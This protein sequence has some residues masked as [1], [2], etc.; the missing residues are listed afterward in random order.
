MNTYIKFITQIFLKSFIYV[1]LIMLSL[2]L[3]LNILSELDFF[4]NI[5]V[6]PLFPIYVSFLNSPSL[7]FEMFPFIFLIST[8]VFFINLFNDNQ[9]E[10][11]K[12][13]GL[14]NSKIVSIIGILSFFLGIF[15]IIIF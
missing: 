7:I 6:K 12:Y 5:D 3:I 4:R 9:I 13:S 2:V 8:Q 1:F 15:I 14:K 11:F 10:I